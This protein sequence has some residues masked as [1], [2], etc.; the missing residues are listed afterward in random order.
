MGI[1]IEN[2]EFIYTMVNINLGIPALLVVSLLQHFHK[3][4]STIGEIHPSINLNLETKPK[5]GQISPILEVHRWTHI[6]DY[7]LH[8]CSPMM[9]R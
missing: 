1:H 6:P 3:T 8:C 7:E 5:S 4:T 9:D 2:G